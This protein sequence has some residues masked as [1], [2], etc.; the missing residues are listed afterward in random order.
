[1]KNRFRRSTLVRFVISVIVMTLW[2]PHAAF[3]EET[4]QPASNGALQLN[5]RAAVLIDA[6]TGQPLFEL[7]ADQAFPPASMAKMMTEY[8]VVEAVQQG[9]IK[10]DDIVTTSEYASKIIGSRALLATGEQLTV[11]EMFTAMAIYSANDATIALAEHI[12]GSE[13]AF[14]KMMNETAKQFGLSKDAN[15]INATGLNREDM[16]DFASPSLMGETMLTAKDAA[17][18]AYHIVTEHPESL[19]YTKLPSYKLR[20][21]D[22]Y[23][24][25]NWNWMVES[26]KD[27]RYL[28][29]YAYE[30]LDGLKT[31]HTSEAG[32]C[33]TGTAVK[34]GM[35]LISVVMG[36]ESESERF[37]ET[38]KLLDYGFTNFEM[39]T[40]V[41]GNT[42]LVQ[43]PMA[44]IKRG[45]QTEL[46]VATKGDIRMLVAKGQPV[47][48]YTAEVKLLDENARTAPL[49]KG[50]KIGEATIMYQGV[51]KTVDVVTTEASEEAGWFRLFFRAIGKLLSDLWTS[52][53]G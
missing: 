26:N 12:A 20:E 49:A 24:M 11:K 33:F 51:S 8:L 46:A 31:G 40:I 53:F 5:V 34:N 30:G 32:F 37:N 42:T 52:V 13:E 14:A 15:F 3:G 1:M 21:R 10:W 4:A 29:K 43:M 7:N 25:I 39:K 19:E 38:R 23:P 48:A 35:R 22:D 6:A 27:N 16:G 28:R 17:K 47:G 18:I 2:I 36:T 44:P 9:K 50:T 41:P 45:V